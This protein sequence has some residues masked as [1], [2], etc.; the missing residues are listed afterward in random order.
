MNLFPDTPQQELMDEAE[1]HLSS[2][3]GADGLAVWAERGWFSP[4]HSG[5]RIANQALLFRLL[6]RYVVDGPFLATVLAA[7]LAAECGDDSLSRAIAARETT[8][9]L[10]QADDPDDGTVS[11]D[12]RGTF[13][14]FG[15]VDS[16]YVLVASPEAVAIVERHDG[17]LV[18]GESCI[19]PSTPMQSLTL[20]RKA[21]CLG[22]GTWFTRGA[23][24]SAAMLAG[25]AEAT[26]DQSAEHARTRQQF[27]R[28]IGAFQA[29][30]HRCSD[31][32]IQAEAAWCQV[33]FASLALG[34][35]HDDARAQVSAAKIVAG[36]AA[37]ENASSNI[38]NHGALG[39]TTLHPA[40]LYLK[41]ACL[42]EY[43]GGSSELHRRILLEGVAT[44]DESF[45]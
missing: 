23:A 34:A 1:R 20:D 30:K 3:S 45:S 39:C 37:I 17:D 18:I 44:R 6:G 27:G 32:A 31:M 13:R 21:R 42:L 26:R 2:H 43:V 14:S 41:R 36:A 29:I 35:G 33:A 9:G 19:D 10:A 11:A 12:V 5:K 8:V 28:P 16:A 15:S 7:G 22:D 38:Q 4:D 24:L 25:I 40:H